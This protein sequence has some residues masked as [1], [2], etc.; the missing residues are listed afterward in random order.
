MHPAVLS[1][2]LASTDAP[3]PHASAW[4]AQRRQLGESALQGAWWGTITSEPGSG[5]DIMRTRTVAAPEGDG[6]RLTGQKHFGSGS[7]ISSYMITTARV[8]GDDRPDWFLVDT[9]RA[10]AAGWDGTDGITLLA[11]WD[12]HGMTATQSHS[13]N[14]EGVHATRIAW[15]GDPQRVIAGAG[16]SVIAWFTAVIVGIVQEA[17]AVARMQLGHDPSAMRAYEQ[18]NWTKALTEAWLIDQAYEGML[19]AIEQEHD[20]MV[21][22]STGKIATAELA[23]SCLTRLARVLGGGTFGRRSPFGHWAEDVR[24]LGF[25]RPPWGLAYDALF[26]ASLPAPATEP[27]PD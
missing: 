1:F 21:Q 8:Q 12:G 7:G 13:F 16:P 2:W 19:R 9:R 27:L 22:A 10:T 24:A 18:V 23:E 20:P 11:P 25:L 6:Y 17:I 3:E 4:Q 15:P 26:A 14:F 5:G